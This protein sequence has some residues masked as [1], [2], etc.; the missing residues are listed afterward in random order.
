MAGTL[1]PGWVTW[2]G[3][4]DEE[5]DRTWKIKFIVDTD[6]FMDGPFTVLNT[7]GL[8]RP[9]ASVWSFGNDIDIWAFC[10]PEVELGI[11]KEREGDPANTWAMVYTFSTKPPKGKRCADQQV[12]DPLMQP[13]KIS[14]TF[15]KYQEEVAFDRFEQP[16]LT[17]SHERIRGVQFD[18]NRP[19]IR[20]EGNI[21]TLNYALVTSLIDNVNDATLWGLP[22]RCVKFSNFSFEEQYYG[23]CYKYY[24]VSM[25]FEINANTFDREEL[26]EGSKALNGKWNKTTGVY[27]L[28]NVAGVAPDRYDPTHFKRYQD[29]Y[30]NYTNAIL[31]G[32]GLPASSVIRL[33]GV[34]TGTFSTLAARVRIEKYTESNLLILGIPAV[35]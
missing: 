26:D 30:G 12:E 7:P 25:E 27:D 20:I 3:G 5:G 18:A 28:V 35:L 1:R 32:E 10:T 31:N 24:K 14:G 4:Q 2:G 9:G 19:T 11:H 15:S 22:R 8:P 33:S 29:R 17:S 13:F 16:V 6:D 21:L 23:Q 34:G